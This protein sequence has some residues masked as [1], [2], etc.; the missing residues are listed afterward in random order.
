MNT[1]LELGAD[2][3]PQGVLPG[4]ERISEAQQA[5]RLADEPL[6]PKKAQKQADDGLF[7]DDS[8]QVDLVD[9]ARS[10]RP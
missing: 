6:K 4:A 8:R 3:R 2:G 1:E 5:Q 9:M 7:G 10:T